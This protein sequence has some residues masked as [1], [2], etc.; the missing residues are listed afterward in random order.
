MLVGDGEDEVHFV[1]I[2]PNGEL[3]VVLRFRGLA[4]R[5]GLRHSTQVAGDRDLYPGLGG[6]I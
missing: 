3:A 6:R 1:D 5:R 4:S 2:G